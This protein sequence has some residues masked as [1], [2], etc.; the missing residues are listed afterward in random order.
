MYTLT[1]FA[2][3]PW[4]IEVSPSPP[5]IAVGEGTTT[6]YRGTSISDTLGPKSSL[7]RAVS[8]FGIEGFCCSECA[9]WGTGGYFLSLKKKVRYCAKLQL[10]GVFTWKTTYTYLVTSGQDTVCPPI[11]CGPIFRGSYIGQK[12]TLKHKKLGK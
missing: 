9:C 5:E 2:S 7:I 1:L 6:E 8:L 11:N 4:A 12:Y 10:L 3:I